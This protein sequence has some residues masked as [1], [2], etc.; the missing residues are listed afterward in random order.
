MPN[1]TPSKILWVFWQMGVPLGG[2]SP[3]KFLIA[4]LL[5]DFFV[6]WFFYGNF[7]STRACHTRSG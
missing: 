1:F 2:F 5:G 4:V 6:L 3:S 7:L